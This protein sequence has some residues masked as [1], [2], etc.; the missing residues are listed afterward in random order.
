ML[1]AYAPMS[2]NRQEQTFKLHIEVR[3]MVLGLI[4]GEIELDFL[5]R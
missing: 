1:Q 3:C 5:K 4:S 2:A